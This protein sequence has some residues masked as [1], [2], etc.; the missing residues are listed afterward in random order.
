VQL[1]RLVGRHWRTVK[2]AKVRTSTRFTITAN[3]PVGVDHHRV[4]FP[5]SISYGPSA[6]RTFTITGT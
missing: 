6:S 3:P 2:R 5:R 1:Q 4:A